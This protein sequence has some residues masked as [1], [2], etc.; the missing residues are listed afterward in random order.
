MEEIHQERSEA[1]RRLSA[2]RDRLFS[3]MRAKKN[4]DLDRTVK[5]KLEEID[6]AIEDISRS[7]YRLE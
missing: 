4:G 7:I 3:M 1:L 6:M 5:C 2:Q